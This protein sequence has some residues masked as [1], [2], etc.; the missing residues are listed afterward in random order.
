MAISIITTFDFI[1]LFHGVLVHRCTALKNLL[2]YVQ[3]VIIG[4]KCIMIFHIDEVN[5]AFGNG[6]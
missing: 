2:R 5:D 1:I 6:L 4:D 3:I